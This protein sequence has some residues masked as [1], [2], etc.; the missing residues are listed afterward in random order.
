[1][2]TY[3]AI[4]IGGTKTRIVVFSDCGILAESETVGVGFS[5]ESKEDLPQYREALCAVAK[6]YKI[7]SV[8][9]NLGGRNVG[10]VRAVTASVF[11]DAACTVVRE[12]EGAAALAFGAQ[13]GA[14]TVLLAGTGTIVCTASARGK[15]ILGGWGM[16]IG[17]GGS[18]YDIGLCAIREALLALDGTDALTPLQKEITGR[19][20][21]I[22]P[23]ANAK[24]ICALRDC[25]RAHLQHTDRRAVASLA[26]TVARHAEKGEADACAILCEA[27]KKMGE[28][29]CSGLKKAALPEKSMIAVSGGLIRILPYWQS[30]FENTIEKETGVTRFIYAPDGLLRGIMALANE[31]EKC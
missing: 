6:K 16:N 25:V 20:A 12:S 4:D 5:V 7:S 28:L 19:D 13:V 1:M 31:N 23:T 18:G 21:P 24:E 17:D 15:C 8:A 27:G 29:V 30:E 9:V 10:Q 2:K 11:P 26:K 3:L 22:P 14:D